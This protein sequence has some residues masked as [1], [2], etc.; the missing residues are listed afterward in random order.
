MEGTMAIILVVEDEAAERQMLALNLETAGHVVLQAGNGTDALE[1]LKKAHPDLILTDVL[2]PE[3]DGFVFCKA[4]REHPQTK[5]IPV[6]VLTARGKMEDAF[7]A[8]GV[9]GFLEKPSA[10]N[11]LLSTI[12]KTLAHYGSHGHFKKAAQKFLVFG[13]YPEVCESI[14]KGLNSQGYHVQ[15]AKTAADILVHVVNFQPDVIILEA[16]LED[17]RSAQDV[18]K[19]IRLF[20][21]HE[22]TPILVYSYYRVSDLASAE[23]RKRAAVIE[24]CA[25]EAM[26]AGATEYF[27]RFNEQSFLEQISKYL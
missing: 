20:P 24:R 15:N 8:L 5:E 19:A 26:L 27:D 2:M 21:H 14:I 7:A 23:F 10:P 1:L 9:A 12:E 3:M 11:V 22:E 13:T 6:I 16:Q 18:V 25:Q 17:G 4:L